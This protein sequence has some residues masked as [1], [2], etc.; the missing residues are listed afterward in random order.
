MKK[1][2]G[3]FT[4]YNR[5]EKTRRC[6]ESLQEDRK[7]QWEFVILDDSSTDGT[8]AMLNAMKN[9]TVREGNGQS[10]YS[11]GMRIAISVAKEKLKK[12]PFDYV[13]LM[14][15]DVKFHT[16]AISRMI[17]Y[18][19]GEKA[20]MVGATEDSAGNYTYG[21]IRKKS[22]WRPKYEHLMSGDKKVQ[23][24]TFNANCVLLP[25]DI[26][27]KLDNID[28]V[29]I[30]SFGDYDYGFAA[31]KKKIPIYVTNF[32]VG[33]CEH[34]HDKKSTWQD[35]SLSRKKRLE[36]KERA[37]GHPGKIWFHFLKKNYN[38]ITAIVY[39]LNDYAK[40]AFKR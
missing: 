9:V 23:C 39:T 21:G 27:M 22:N 10:Y 18:L 8:Q 36:L 35:S 33:I 1:V 13:V 20:I 5:C 28:P 32:Y 2:L 7:I 16:D 4:C 34:D 25:S 17:T 29:Y 12:E 19:N 30:H 31:R 24:D 15:D 26:F 40:I 6:L 37:L 3:L 14:N 11:G 38:I